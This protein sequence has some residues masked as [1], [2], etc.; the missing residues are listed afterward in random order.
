[1]TQFFEVDRRDGP[2]RIGHVRTTD[3]LRTPGLVGDRLVDA[4]SEWVADRS[5][6]ADPTAL[7]VLPHRAFPAGTPAE[8]Q[9]TLDPSL[10]DRDAPTA[11]VVTPETAGDRGTDAYVL[12]GAPAIDRDARALLDRVVAVREAI[13]P[14][15]ALYLP[16]LATP[17]LVPTLVYAGADLFDEDRAVVA[18]RAGRYL[19]VEG[20]RRLQDLDTLPCACPTCRDRTPDSFDREACV[21]HNVA[22]LKAAIGTVRQR[23]AEGRLRDY[24]EGQSRQARWLAEAVERLDDTEYLAQRTPIV[25][26]ATMTATGD[27]TVRRP[28]IRRFAD[29][30]VE[31]FEAR[32]A[33]TAVLVPCSAT[34][35][36]GDSPSHREFRDAIDYRAHTVSLTSP[37]GVVPQELE[38]T[39]PAQH[40]DTVVTGTWTETEIA[41]VAGTL[42]RYLDAQDYDR[43][44]AHVPDDYRPIVERATAPLDL[45]VVRTAGEDHPR[46]R[47]ALDRLD[48]ALAG[49][50]RY[51]KRA[52]QHATIRAIADY[53]FGAGAGDAIFEDLAVESVHPKL[54]ALDGD[55]TQ[56][57]AVVPEYGT[58]AFTLAGAR[59]WL[60]ADVRTL[61]AD[62]DDFVPHGSVLAP[63]VRGADPAIRV[64]DEVVFEG[65][66]AIAVGRATMSGPEMAASTRGVAC[67][68]R[69][70]EQR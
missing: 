13:P 53:Q 63:G 23:I 14:D 43:V 26:N 19:T 9:D 39:Y 51:R 34:K 32:L 46:D 22:A 65:P 3:P 30:V 31:R 12:S 45:D 15:S 41:H 4:G 68:V 59:R 49:E 62:I 6:E 36:Y 55:G 40:Y 66:S 24:I 54:R 58:L 17:R 38:L 18:G 67:E 16:G 5:I 47:D 29:R 25:R 28:E 61:R 69:H 64:G 2:A 42:R 20:S 33:D 57:A 60:D 1:M 8:I 7:T 35:P 70:V 27:A 37:L 56:L 21:E 11:A 44:L 48:D 10:P 52:R 50:D